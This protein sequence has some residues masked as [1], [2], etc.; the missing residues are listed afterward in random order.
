LRPWT[1]RC[2]HLKQ[3]KKTKLFWSQEK[4]SHEFSHKAEGNYL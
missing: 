2:L 4:N 3:R 1:R